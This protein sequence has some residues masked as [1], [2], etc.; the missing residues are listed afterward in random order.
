MIYFVLHTFLIKSYG[1]WN[2]QIKLKLFFFFE[3]T[4]TMV[5]KYYENRQCNKLVLIS[6]NVS[7]SPLEDEMTGYYFGRERHWLLSF[8]LFPVQS[9]KHCD[10][11]N[12][13]QRQW[14]QNLLYNDLFSRHSAG[15]IKVCFSRIACHDS[16]LSQ[17]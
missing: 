15:D 3:K 14:L 8:F 11:N 9:H 17:K 5:Y 4:R 13:I 16:E 6:M 2:V 7:H 10:N 12:E 1:F